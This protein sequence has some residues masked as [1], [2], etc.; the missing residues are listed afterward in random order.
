MPFGHLKAR[1]NFRC[2]HQK[3]EQ[4]HCILGT[5]GCQAFPLSHPNG[6]WGYRFTE[7]G[8]T[9]IFI[10]DNELGFQHEGG[11]TRDRYIEI[12]RG[13]DLLLHDAQ[14]TDEEYGQKTR[15]W[16]HTTF[17]EAVDLAIAAGVGRLGLLHHDPDRTDDALDR[18]LDLCHKR[19]EQAGSAIECLACAEG[20]VFDLS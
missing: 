5:M 2:D 7:N 17:R 15:G 13:A 6:G 1:F 20:M 4:G 10:S 12:C 3:S 11:L 18:Q 16:G 9:L 19:L 8:K 14:Y